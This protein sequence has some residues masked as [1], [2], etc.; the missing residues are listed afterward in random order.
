M[1]SIFLMLLRTA[2]CVA[3]VLLALVTDQDPRQQARKFGVVF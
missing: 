2:I 1:T 3:D